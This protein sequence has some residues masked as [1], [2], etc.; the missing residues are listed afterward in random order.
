MAYTKEQ[1]RAQVEALVA[2]FRANEASLADVPEAQIEDNYIRK[3][4]RYLNWNTDNTGL[5]VAEWEFVL[6]RTDDKGK[7]PD[8]ILQ[9]DGQQLLVMDAKKV[10]YDMHDPRWVTQVYAY[11]YSTQSMPTHRKID[12][13]LLTDFQE[14]ILLDCTLYAA[15]SKAVGNFRILDWTYADY[16]LQFDTLWELFERENMRSAA[17]TRNSKAPAGLWAQYLSPKKVKANRIAPDKAFLA[18]MDDE[19]TGWRVRLAKDMKKHNPAAGGALIT[20]AV[21]LLIDRLIFIKALSD[22]E[23]EADYLSE[24]AAQVEKAGLA[25]GDAGWFNACRDIFSKLNQFYNGSIFEPRP[26]L[27]SVTVSNKV[28]REVLRD[29]QPEN[30]PYNFAVLPVELLGTIYERFLGRVVH[31][32]DARVR[33]EEKPEVRKAGGVFYTPQ[34]IVEYIVQH[35]LG[36]LLAKCKTPADAAKLKVLDP[37]CGSGSFLLG[38]Y[39]ALIKWHTDWYSDKQ[40]LTQQDREAAYYDSDGRVRLTAKLKRQILLNNLFGVDIDAQAVEVTRFSLSLKALEDTRRDELYEEVSLFKQSVLPD[41]RH[42]IKCGNSLIGPEYF[43]SL[44]LIDPDDL[45]L[46]NPFDWAKEFPTIM[47]AGGFDTIIGNP[48]YLNIDDSWGK[49]DPRL[50]AIKLSYPHIYNDKTDILFYFM[51]R[52]MELCK[53]TVAFIVSRA[54]L[55]AYKANKL[56]EYL[57]AHSAVTQIVD[58]RNFYVFAGV[59]ITT[60]LITYSPRKH[61]ATVNIYKLLCADLPSFALGP[62]LSDD[63]VFEHF[64]I[65]QNRLS[66]ATWALTSPVVTDLNEKIDAAGSSI[67]TILFIGQ[68]MQTGC[69]EVFGDRTEAEILRWRVKPT[70][71]FKRASNSD[72][73]RYSIRDRQEFILYT[74]SA[75]LFDELSAGVKTHL[76]AHADLLKQRAAYKRGDCEWWQYTWPLHQSYYGRKRIICPYLATRNRFALDHQNEFLGLTDTVVL[77]DNGQPESLHYLLAVLNSKLLTFRFRSIGKLKSAGIYEY[78]WNSISKLAVRRIDFTAPADKLR[79][80]TMIVLV[81]SMLALQKHKA[82][83][84]TQPEQELL[85]RQIEVTDRQIDALVYELYELTPVEIA[86]V[87]GIG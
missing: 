64:Q 39:A 81:E 30:S 21:Q 60:C 46:V 9:L 15:D 37:A 75:S 33:I 49:G 84:Q 2:N 1:A 17:A 45:L 47:A 82:A 24:L 51:A 63:S 87:E 53:G 5:S 18:E 83:A 41:L 62:L 86:I 22:R 25:A 57:A 77:F 14:F 13:A 19:K 38:A 23:I 67:G 32:T 8:Y 16:A 42:N 72:I 26:E 78:F 44:L 34:Y 59:G 28:V 69:N 3:L 11:A 36:E 10:K 68:G 73:Q 74:P 71:R 80:D 54:F 40:R 12:F 58:L 20:A 7:R 48:P 56:R 70:Q 27:E 52:A 29:L 61:P 6:Q 50:T 79:H 66:S 85:Q 76:G 35:T 31:A 65:A 55:E 43:K 4:F